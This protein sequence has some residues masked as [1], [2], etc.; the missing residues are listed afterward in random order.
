MTSP[1]GRMDCT[2][3]FTF[4]TVKLSP[5]PNF[6]NLPRHAI[7]EPDLRRAVNF[8]KSGHE[9]KIGRVDRLSRRGG[10]AVAIG[11]T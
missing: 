1:S 3:P 4:P 10:A 5:I 2:V 11:R 8:G 6:H 7:L 9:G